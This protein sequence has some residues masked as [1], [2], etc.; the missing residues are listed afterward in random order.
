M[1]LVHMGF[2]AVRC[3]IVTER[4]SAGAFACLIVGKRE[5]AARPESDLH[6]RH[7]AGARRRRNATVAFTINATAIGVIVAVEVHAESAVS[8]SPF[9]TAQSHRGEHHASDADAEF[10]KRLTS[11]D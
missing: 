11:C 2:V 1:K 7:D 9:L 3:P 6:C 5:T 8:S 4:L 10:L